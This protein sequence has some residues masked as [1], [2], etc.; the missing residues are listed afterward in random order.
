MI[1][2]TPAM[3]HIT[4]QLESGR[5]L[6]QHLVVLV[7]QFQRSNGLDVDGKPGPA[8]IAAIER[9]L[10]RVSRVP[11]EKSWPLPQLIDGRKPV[12]TSRFKTHNPSRPHHNGVDMFYPYR[13]HIDG[14]V[15]V[16]DGGAARGRDGQPKWFIPDK[17]NARVA[18]D[19]VVMRAD[20]I[21]TGYRVAVEH[22]DGYETIYCHLRGLLVRA[23]QQVS[24]GT[25]L[26]EVGDNPADVDAEHMHFEVSP[27]GKYA[28]VDPEPWLEGATFLAA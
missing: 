16:G 25:E 13:A 10:A 9:L 20:R 2:P 14:P 6:P 8:T 18:A 3:A 1:D 26:G 28:P 22:L 24:R 4:R 27:A 11:I 12:I 21:A 7:M 19:G 15:K 5:L 23:G 17:M